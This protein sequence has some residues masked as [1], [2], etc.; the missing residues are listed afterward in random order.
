MISMKNE[1]QIKLTTHTHTQACSQGS[2]KKREKSS[3]RAPTYVC[4]LS[5]PPPQHLRPA[6]NCW[7]PQTKKSLTA[8][9][10]QCDIVSERGA[11]F[12]DQ[13]IHSAFGSSSV[14]LWSGQD[15][16]PVNYILY[17]GYFCWNIIITYCIRL[18]VEACITQFFFSKWWTLSF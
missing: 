5:N 4:G 13:N 6:H 12:L 18:C 15:K 1:K 16:R 9:R 17:R 11:K 10:E 8:S 7:S 14:Y 3:L 2:A